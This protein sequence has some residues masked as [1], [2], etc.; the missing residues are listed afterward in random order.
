MSHQSVAASYIYNIAGQRVSNDTK[1]IVIKD[2]K[3]IM[4]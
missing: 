4:K 1:G 3:K 2:G